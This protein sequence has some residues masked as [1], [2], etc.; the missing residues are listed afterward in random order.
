MKTGFFSRRWALLA[1]LAA[2]VLMA[3]CGGGEE[4]KDKKVSLR[5][6]NLSTDVPS[7][8][9]YTGDTRR[10]GSLTGD[11]VSGATTLDAGTYTLAVKAAGQTPVLF[12]ESFAPTR[13][14]D[15]TTVIAGRESKLLVSTI[16]ENEDTAGIAAGS[17]RLR[18]LNLVADM[19]AVDVYVVPTG[20]GIGG[21]PPIRFTA[22]GLGAFVT[23]SSATGHRVVVTGQGN[24]NNVRLD[25]PLA[26]TVDKQFHTLALVSGGHGSLLNA[27]LI[28]QGGAATPLKNTHARVR[29]VAGADAGGNV[30]ATVG[31]AALGEVL[32]S[33]NVGTYRLVH[34]GARP[35]AVS[36]DGA[37]T[38]STASLA[39]GADYTVLAF[40]RSTAPR[41][42]LLKDDNRAPATDTDAYIRLVNGVDG[43]QAMTLK[44]G[45]GSLVTDVAP[46]ADAAYAAVA[47]AT[48][49]RVEVTTPGGGTIF[50]LSASGNQ[51][52]LQAQGVYTLFMLGGNASPSGEL[53][54]DR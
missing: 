29:L 44:V 22:T 8:D 38:T 50:T 27:S 40:G 6:I 33:P 21:N 15:H 28:P 3:A 36:I 42:K 10:F 26:G 47:G 43:A 37:V 32:R 53:S 16:G 45:F 35:L 13:G 5:A 51:P 19:P 24:L 14:S 25:I 9:V 34:A 54:K 18:V 31:G 48:S 4:S 12:S 20:A 41:V 30:S 17:F 2:V 1:P 11:A 46:G 52:L 23:L 7:V 49:S 39:A